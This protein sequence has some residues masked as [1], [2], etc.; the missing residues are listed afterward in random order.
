MKT[1]FVHRPEKSAR[2]ELTTYVNSLEMAF[3]N[4]IAVVSREI[5]LVRKHQIIDNTSGKIIASI[6]PVPHSASLF[7]QTDKQSAATVQIVYSESLPCRS[8][9][10]LEHA[11]DDALGEDDCVETVHIQDVVAKKYT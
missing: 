3:A 7:G 2:Q 6:Y 9:T 8:I 4:I 5:S 10:I 1:L 11:V